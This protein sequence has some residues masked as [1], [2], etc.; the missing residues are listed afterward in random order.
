MCG[1]LVCEAVELD[2]L[3]WSVPARAMQNA[4]QGAGSYWQAELGITPVVENNCRNDII[5]SRVCVIISDSQ[6]HK[7]ETI[8]H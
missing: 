1:K 4:P 6:G 7:F 8:F 3:R 2:E 5:H